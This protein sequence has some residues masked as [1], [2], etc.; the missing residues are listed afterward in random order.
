M[1][2]RKSFTDLMLSSELFVSKRVGD[3]VFATPNLNTTMEEQREKTLERILFFRSK[4]VFK[5]WLT[6]SSVD[7]ALKRAAL[8]ETLSLFDHSLSIKLGVH[9]HLWGGAIQ[10]LGGKRHHDKWLI[11]TE[12]Y[13][14]RGCF[15]MSE[16]GHGSNVS[17]SS[18]YWVFQ[19][20]LPINFL[21]YSG[22]CRI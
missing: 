18:N 16:L 7:D 17:T 6:D 13:Q 15:A 5:G 20:K 1:E 2:E 21:L 14:V 3:R 8:F 4:G 9:I 10:Y 19:S 11:P 22:D 12:A